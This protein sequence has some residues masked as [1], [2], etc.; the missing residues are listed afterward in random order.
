MVT[1]VLLSNALLPNPALTVCM[2]MF[3]C[4]YESVCVIDCMIVCWWLCGYFRSASVWVSLHVAWTHVRVLKCVLVQRVLGVFLKI[5]GLIESRF[6]SKKLGERAL[7]A[8]QPLTGFEGLMRDRRWCFFLLSCAKSCWERSSR[9]GFCMCAG[10][11]LLSTE[12]RCNLLMNADVQKCPSPSVH[13][14]VFLL[15]EC[16]SS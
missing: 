12:W 15:N 2:C 16:P 3:S 4:L 13:H 14:F 5:C 11:L 7:L 10:L 8:S 6:C 9:E 1:N